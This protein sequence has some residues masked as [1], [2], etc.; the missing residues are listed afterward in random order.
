MARHLR[1]RSS[2]RRSPLV[3]R[4]FAIAI[5]TT[6]TAAD[7]VWAEGLDRR[8]AARPGGQLQVDL[9]FGEEATWERVSLEVRSHDADE[10]WAVADV[11][12]LGGSALSFRFEHDE[13]GVRVYGRAGGIMSWLFG[14]PGVTVR[15]W[16][17]RDYS[18]DLRCSSGPIRVEEVRGRIR[19]RTL[20]APIEVRAAEGS[21][22]L[23]T[24]TGSVQV[25]DMRGD[26]DVRAADGSIELSWIAGDVEVRTGHGDVHARHLDGRVRIRTDAGEIGLNELR[27]VADLK[28]ERGA[29]FVAF[30]DAP[31]GELETRLG[32]VEVVFPGHTGIELDARTGSGRV[33]LGPG[34]DVKGDQSAK[35]VV[36]GINGSGESLVLYTERG[37]IRLDR[38]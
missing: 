5:L 4:A 26:V 8:V 15:V 11:S 36:G 6:C 37:N 14:G 28:T 33:E 22:D 31:A 35:Q 38:R 30:A 27:G 10:V 3:L 29:I 2:R 21:L 25:D 1:A 32:P 23:H 9:D 12:G 24:R 16:V 20:D 17:P 19:A 7:A 18:V 34:I 13:S